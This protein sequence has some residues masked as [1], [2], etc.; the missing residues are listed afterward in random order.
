[1]CDKEELTIQV[2]A[3]PAD[4]NPDGDI[5]G[6]WLLSQ[7]DLAAGV[8]AQK[9][10]KC[11]VVTIAIDSMSFKAPVR[12]GDRIC[13]YAELLKVGRTSMSIKVKVWVTDK[14][15]SDRRQVTEGIFTFVA[16]DEDGKPQPVNRT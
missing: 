1:M 4:A 12:I 13:C 5:F 15:T 16:I 10:A 3:M 7:M 8:V 2:V 14:M 11:R 6:G 9:E